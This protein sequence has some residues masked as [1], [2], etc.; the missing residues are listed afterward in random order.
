MRAGNGKQEIFLE[1]HQ[2]SLVIIDGGRGGAGATPTILLGDAEHPQFKAVLCSSRHVN[3]Q[4]LI[5]HDRDTLI[6]QSPQ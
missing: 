5:N 1:W 2:A 6:E 4:K 3:F